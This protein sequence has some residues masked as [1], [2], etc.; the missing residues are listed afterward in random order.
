MEEE[1][2]EEVEVLASAAVRGWSPAGGLARGVRGAGRRLL[3]P[4]PPGGILPL[5]RGPRRSRGSVSVGSGGAAAPRRRRADPATLDAAAREF[6]TRLLVTLYAEAGDEGGSAQADADDS[7]G[8][9]SGDGATSDSATAAPDG[10]GTHRRD[11]RSD[12]GSTD[13]GSPNDDDEAESVDGAVDDAGDEPSRA[14]ARAEPRDSRA[15]R[16]AQFKPAALT[17][18]GVPGDIGSDLPSDAKD[19]AEGAV[20]AVATIGEPEPQRSTCTRIRRD[21]RRGSGPERPRRRSRQRADDCDAMISG[22]QTKY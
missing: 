3:P 1:E 21:Y 20:E 10:S 9:T 15:A 7:E 13:G 12:D 8:N 22:W 14:P 16:R 4:P 6:V 17:G 18:D 2:E 11:D 5:P 19:L